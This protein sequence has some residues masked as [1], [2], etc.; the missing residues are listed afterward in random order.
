[1][2]QPKRRSVVLRL[3]LLTFAIYSIVQLTQLQIQLVQKKKDIEQQEI[4]IE[5]QRIKNRELSDLLAKG[6]ENDLIERAAKDKLDYVYANE[7]VF[8]GQ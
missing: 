7:E 6:T 1:M 3:A 5:N 8:T 2:K 4:E